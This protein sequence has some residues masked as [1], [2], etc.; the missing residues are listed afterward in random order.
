MKDELLTSLATVVHH[1]QR[2]QKTPKGALL[3]L[4]HLG[5]RYRTGPWIWMGA[6]S[7]IGLHPQQFRL[8]RQLVLAF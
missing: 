8:G 3:S 2:T 6:L 7:V 1:H 5:N 4:R